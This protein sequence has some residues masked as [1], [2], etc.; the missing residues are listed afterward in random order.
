MKRAPDLFLCDVSKS[1]ALG[2]NFAFVLRYYLEVSGTESG[3]SPILKYTLNKGYQWKREDLY[4]YRER[5]MQQRLI[6]KRRDEW[7]TFTKVVQTIYSLD[8]FNFLNLQ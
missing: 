8:K 7:T 6:T 2:S 4:T 1:I 5:E 3:K